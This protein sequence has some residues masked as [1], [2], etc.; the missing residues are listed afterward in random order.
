M[1]FTPSVFSIFYQ[2]YK[3]FVY[4]S[5]VLAHCDRQEDRQTESETDRHHA[6]SKHNASSTYSGGSSIKIAGLVAFYNILSGNRMGIVLQ[7]WGSHITLSVYG[8]V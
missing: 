4:I 2:K 6:H 7:V 3:I 5:A 8:V 1:G